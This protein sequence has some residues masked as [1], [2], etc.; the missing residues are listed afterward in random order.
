[1]EVGLVKLGFLT[2]SDFAGCFTRDG[3]EDRNV[4]FSTITENGICYA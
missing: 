2:V 1:M 3:V 4:H